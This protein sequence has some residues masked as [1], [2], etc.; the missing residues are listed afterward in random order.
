MRSSNSNSLQSDLSIN[1]QACHRR[2]SSWVVICRFAE[3]DL[4]LVLGR[5]L[6]SFRLEYGGE[7]EEDRREMGQ[8]YN[9]LLFPDRPLRIRF[10]PRRSGK[11]SIFV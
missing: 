10:T 1:I 8:V 6:Q 5:L 2:N 9:T 7:A 4:Y 11:Y 3:Q